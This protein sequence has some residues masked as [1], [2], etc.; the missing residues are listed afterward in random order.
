MSQNDLSIA[1]Q[2]F[3]SFRSDL[4]SALQAL[5]STNSGTSAPSTTYAN[6]LFYDTTNNIL[7]IRNEDNDA[8]ISLFTLDQTNDNIESLTING[9]L[10]A[11]SLAVDNFT[12]NGTEL[13]LSS[14]D[15]TLDV[16]GDIILDADGGDVHFQDSGSSN[17]FISIKNS[18]GSCVLSNPTADGDITFQGND[19]GV[20]AV[21]ALVLD[22][23]ESGKATFN[24]G[25]TIGSSLT[26]SGS[27]FT[28]SNTSNGNNIDIKTT[29]SGSLV[30]AV[31]IH[32][33]GR[34]EAKQG[35]LVGGDASAN[36][37]DDYEEGTFTPFFGGS[38]GDPS[39]SY[40]VQNGKYTKVGDM[41]C[42]TFVVIAT[43][44]PSGGG[45]S[46]LIAGLPFAFATTNTQAQ[47]CIGIVNN[48]TNNMS[49][50]QLALVGQSNGTNLNVMNC[51]GTSTTSTNN[52]GVSSVHNSGARI[53]GT[54][55]YSITA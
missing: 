26:T 41:V 13:D 39:A 5:G 43:G 23:S 11:D 50:S 42:A 49:T 3:A 31:K 32:S 19:S 46:L 6:Q 15:F 54:I 33:G 14:G 7:K 37:L 18:S 2:G 36:L 51:A 24:A 28:L 17:R 22:M 1:N 38:S 10:T 55:V 4:N 30:H 25:I 45:G 8:F 20:G 35:L 21:N 48:I 52:I 9:T 53:D 40:A 47:G 16:A 29:S 27:P 44:T 12:L 34:L